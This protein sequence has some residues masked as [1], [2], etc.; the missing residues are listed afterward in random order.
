MNT[1]SIEYS[2]PELLSAAELLRMHDL[3]E[4]DWDVAKTTVSQRKNGFTQWV[5][6]QRKQLQS[7]WPV[8]QGVQIEPIKIVGTNIHEGPLTAVIVPDMHVGYRRTSDS[9]YVPLHDPMACQIVTAFIRD[10]QPDIV[11]MLGDNLDL[12]EWSSKYLVTPDLAFTTQMS[13]EYLAEWISSWRAYTQEVI[14]LEGNHEKRMR[15]ALVTNLRAACDLHVV[16][17]DVEDPVLSVPYLLGLESM[18]VVWVGDYPK[19]E[20]W[21]NSNLCVKHAG[22]LSAQPGQTAGKS[23]EGLSHSTIFGHAHRL[24]SAHRTLWR[25]N[26][27]Y[28]Y[29]AYCMGTLAHIDGRVPSNTTNEN[30][31]QGFGIVNLYD[32]DRFHV[33]QIPIHDNAAY[34]GGDCYYVP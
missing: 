12:A 14:Y 4:A 29:A 24:E 32:D 19:G 23:L 11:I 6:F 13:M 27:P 9:N 31:Q 28:I 15:D 2:G 18:G 20:Y 17:E 8:V 1:Q 22:A 26:K 34:F 25:N 10:I 21:L 5:R 3:N 16:G 7:K 30:W 33:T